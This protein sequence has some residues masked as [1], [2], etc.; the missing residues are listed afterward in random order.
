[1]FWTSPWS[2]TPRRLLVRRAIALTAAAGLVGYLALDG[3][4]YDV[5][6][7]QSVA[8]GV[9]IAVAIGFATGLLPRAQTGRIVLVPALAAAALAGW[10]LLSFGWTPSDGRTM[11]ELA[12]LLAYAGFAVLALSALNRD[13]FR[14]AA[15]GLSVAALAIVALAVASRLAPDAFPDATEVA[16]RFR[17]D[18]LDFP[19]DYWNAIGAWGA[20]SM[21]I[22]L[23]WSAHARFALTRALALAAVPAAG[24]AVYLSYSRGGVVGTAAALA[25]VLVL[26]RNRWTAFAH[27]LAAGAGTG[28]AIAV[29]RSNPQI[30]EATGGAG[31][32]EVALALAGAAALCAGAVF[33]TG[34]LRADEARLPRRQARLAVPA[35]V[36]VLL[37]ATVVAGRGPISDWWDEFRT[38]DAPVTG[39][40]DPA[41]RLTTA[42]GNRNDIW[43]SAI[44]AFEDSPVQ[45]IGPGTFE[46]WW[47]READDPEYVR[48]AHSL[49]LE[50][51]AELGLPGVLLLVTA[52]GGLLAAAVAAR[53]RLTRPG[54]LGA[55]VAL[56]GAFAVFLVNAGVDWMWEETAVAVLG[57]GG[58]AVAAAA[59]SAR[60][61]GSRRRGVLLKPGVRAAV[62]AAAACA[63]LAQ[64][65]G[66]VS[67]QRVRAS[68]A[69]LAVGDESGARVLAEQAIDAEPWA[70]APHAQLAVV[71][72]EAGNLGAAQDEIEAAIEREPESWEWPLVLAPIQVARDDR[73][74]AIRTFGA[75][76]ELAPRLPFYSPF[77]QL[78]GQRIFTNDELEEIFFRR[79]ARARERAE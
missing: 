79:Q 2:E 56:T 17:T 25:A 9:W 15:A 22:G 77:S 50:V 38:E 66:L 59:G 5:V 1:M 19:L 13:T 43:T 70:A 40:D 45:G 78:Y 58:I 54:D 7:R 62:V 21:A 68:E 36:A 71:E 26:S 12:R 39:A 76:R 63:A 41:E 72:R 37:I 73:R 46:F 60:R 8:F 74:G 44:D 27:A 47:L 24:L 42:G 52:L 28:V 75:G 67:T 49:Y 16:A 51:A 33:A 3:G 55:S 29:V 31:A 35:L 32:G 14:A 61:T 65:P 10:I 23:A 34:V 20:M 57:I 30:A 64:I 48:D 11:A 6:V 18:R 53:R 69:A 4:G